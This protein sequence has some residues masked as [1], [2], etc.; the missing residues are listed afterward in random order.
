MAENNQ[1]ET[2]RERLLK[3]AEIL[4]AEKGYHAVSVRE[5]TRAAECNLAAVN[6]HFGNKNNLYLEVFRSRWLPRANKMRE[7]F[8]KT[9][10]AQDHSSPRALVQALAGAFLKGPLSDQERLCHCQLIIRELTKPTEAFRL[11][12]DASMRPFFADL[13]QRLRPYLPDKIDKESLALN[14][15]S[16]FAMVV[17]FNFAREAVT[18]ITGCEY[19]QDFKTRL[20]EH[21]T[22]FS[23]TGL[24]ISGEEKN[25]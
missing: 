19:D 4:F 3:E 14:I 15:F 5:I 10:A 11:V 6:Y 9:L 21:I 25:P 17:H 22:D 12:V 23:L 20:V 18:H 13:S 8:E 24:G 1:L 7:C 2:A 16:I